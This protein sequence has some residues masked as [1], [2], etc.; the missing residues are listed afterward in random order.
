MSRLH[1]QDGYTCC[2]HF[3][4]WILHEQLWW[5]GSQGIEGQKCSK[6]RNP[7]YNQSSYTTGEFSTVSRSP[8]I[9]QS[10]PTACQPWDDPHLY[11]L[12]SYDIAPWTLGAQS[13]PSQFARSAEQ[14]STDPA[15]TYYGTRSLSDTSVSTVSESS[16]AEG[17]GKPRREVS[18]DA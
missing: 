13:Q 10:S 8:N 15:S 5:V 4:K 16:K 17:N 18:S 9:P 12:M 2:G 6:L 14:F 11:Y 3:P 1:G 7:Q